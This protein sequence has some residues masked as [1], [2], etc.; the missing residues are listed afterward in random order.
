MEEIP[1]RTG[2]PNEDG[3]REDLLSLSAAAKGAPDGR[4]RWVLFHD[5]TFF[6]FLS[7]YHATLIALSSGSNIRRP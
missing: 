6:T 2:W 7:L 4:P 1:R 3:L 5:A